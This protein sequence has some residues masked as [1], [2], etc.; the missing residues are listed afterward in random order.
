MN[1]QVLADFEGSLFHR[2]PGWIIQNGGTIFLNC[3]PLTSS[4]K[5]VSGL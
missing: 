2:H 1:L 4:K 5:D 3:K